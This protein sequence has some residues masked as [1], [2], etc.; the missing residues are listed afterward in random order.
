MT[1]CSICWD[2]I[3][4]KQVVF[5]CCHERYYHLKCIYQWMSTNNS[6]P[7]CRKEYYIKDESTHTT[8]NID[9]PTE[10]IR[11]E[12]A[13]NDVNNVHLLLCL[14]TIVLISFGIVTVF[15]VKEYAAI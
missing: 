4:D 3:G 2:T 9:N 8:L 14:F 12:S 15:V 7:F 10:S 11:N 5:N 13:Y 1:E 6:C